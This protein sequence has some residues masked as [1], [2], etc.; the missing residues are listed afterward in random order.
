MPRYSGS[1]EGD[2]AQ[3]ITQRPRVSNGEEKEE[4]EA[5]EV[6]KKVLLSLQK[7]VGDKERLLKLVYGND[8]DAMEAEWITFA[9]TMHR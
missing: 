9:K 1:P 6:P 2:S 8:K 5:P 3:G 4:G 7:G